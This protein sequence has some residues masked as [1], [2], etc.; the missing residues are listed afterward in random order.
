MKIIKVNTVINGC[1]DY[2]EGFKVVEI[3]NNEKKEKSYKCKNLDFC[4]M[5]YKAIKEGEGNK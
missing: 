5:A 4:I 3:E 1:A 2:C